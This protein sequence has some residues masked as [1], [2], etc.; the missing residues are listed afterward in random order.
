MNREQRRNTVKQLQKKGLTKESA[1]TFVDR[2]EYAEQGHDYQLWE[3]EKVK[4]NYK[5][6][7][8]YKDWPK[9]NQKYRDFVEANK[10]TVLTVEFDDVRRKEASKNKGVTSMCQFA[11]DA[12]EIK[13][14]FYGVDLLP[15]PNQT[16]PKT[17]TELQNEAFMAHVDEVLKEMK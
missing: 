11:E 6:I 9:L 7:T 17:E 1:Q 3:G 5:R 14:L 4:L 13:W 8:S 2:M 16:K 10:N 12:S 15:E